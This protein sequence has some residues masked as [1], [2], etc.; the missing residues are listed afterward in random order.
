MPF[1][2]VLREKKRVT[3]V[4]NNLILNK[5]NQLTPKFPCPNATIPNPPILKFNR[6]GWS[7]N[8][9]QRKI[10]SN[11]ENAKKSTGPKS[12]SG[13]AK[14]SRNAT[15]LGMYTKDV[16]LPTEDVAQYIALRAAFHAE[17]QPE[18]P[19]E[20]MLVD[21]IVIALWRRRRLQATEVGFHDYRMCE[22]AAALT[23]A[24][25]WS[26]QTP[27]WPMRFTKITPVPACSPISGA[28]TPASNGQSSGPSK[29]SSASSR[30]VPRSPI[31][32]AQQNQIPQIK[33]KSRRGHQ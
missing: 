4:E 21:T 8:M 3:R 7:K 10:E 1:L 27:K 25:T 24:T 23:G 33:P 12:E 31:P 32:L 29:N 26:L 28:T 13:K 9:S 15:T 20:E 11:R 2:C 30:S 6:K 18:T 5:T 14:S 17:H 22:L 16:V 19:T